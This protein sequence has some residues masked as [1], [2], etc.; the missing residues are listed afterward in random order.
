[1]KQ[2]QFGKEGWT[3]DRIKDLKDQTFLIT[4]A[5]SGTGYEAAKILLSKGA[6]VVMLN[7]NL[8]KSENTSATFKEELGNDIDVSHIHMDL[9]ELDSVR[10]AADEVLKT[11]P[12]IDALIC[13]AAI[14]QVPK[15]TFTVDGFESQL[16]DTKINNDLLS[17]SIAFFVRYQF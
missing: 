16:G 9:A 13:N 15:Q 2:N 3:P 1:M 6:C 7:R 14:A 8:E 5:T 11:V 12:Q 4:G 17:Q 10:N